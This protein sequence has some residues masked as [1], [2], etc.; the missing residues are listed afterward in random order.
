VQ[1]GQLN[2]LLV[3]TQLINTY[4]ELVKRRPVLE[5]VGA[6]LG[7]ANIDVLDSKISVS[8]PTG[9]QLIRIR[10]VDTDPRVAAAIAN[11][12]ADA[13]MNVSSS[14]ISRP[15]ALALVEPAGIPSAP[16]S[17]DV[18]VNVGV[19]FILA[20]VAGVTAVLLLERTNRPVNTAHD[21]EDSTGL[22]TLATL[23]SASGRTMSRAWSERD[24]SNWSDAFRRLR[25]SLNTQGLGQEFNSLLITSETPRVGKS[26]L[27]ANLAVAYSVAGFKVLLV[28]LNFHNPVQHQIFGLPNDTGI[29]NRLAGGMGQPVPFLQ[30][31]FPN[32]FITPAGTT[33]RHPDDLLAGGLPDDFAQAALSYVNIMVVDCPA[34]SASPD[35]VALAD[36]LD[37]SLIVAASGKTTVNDLSQ[38]AD[39]LEGLKAK[40]LGVV[41]NKTGRTLRNTGS[42]GRQQVSL[43][44]TGPGLREATLAEQHDHDMEAAVAHSAGRNRR[45]RR[46]RAAENVVQEETL[47]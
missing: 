20:L 44:M 22:P 31:D 8:N 24:N 14:A 33:T 2:N 41:L 42:R 30:T 21:V 12:I 40:L 43:R 5:Q 27:A 1:P 17:P 46:P 38:A 3:D 32:L 39:R 36:N 45:Q 9:T 10:A 34:F 29:A 16:F 6:Q 37:A 7:I 13:F 28:D 4:L 26:I 25:A 19:V 18:I 11:G 47:S 35:V 23:P 15:G